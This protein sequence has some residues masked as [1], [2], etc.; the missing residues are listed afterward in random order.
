[1][2]TP[3]NGDTNWAGF[4]ENISG[5]QMNFNVPT[6]AQ[7]D[8]MFD[9]GRPD[10]LKSWYEQQRAAGNDNYM[11]QQAWDPNNSDFI[12]GLNNLWTSQQSTGGDY[13]PT[14]SPIDRGQAAGWRLTD[15]ANSRLK[16]GGWDLGNP[17]NI[18]MN[19]PTSEGGVAWGGGINSSDPNADWKNLVSSMTY[20]NSGTTA[21]NYDYT[22][23]PASGRMV[24]TKGAGSDFIT[25]SGDMNRKALAAFG[26]VVGA[27]L[28]IPAIAG[29]AGGAGAGAVAGT[30][31]MGMGAAAG[32]AAGSFSGSAL[33]GMDL[34]N[35]LQYANYASKGLQYGGQLT[36]NETLANIGRY[37]NMFTGLGT[38]V[39]GLVDGA[40][41]GNWF[42]ALKG[43]YGAYSSGNKI[44]NSLT[45]D[46]SSPAGRVRNPMINPTQGTGTGPQMSNQRNW[47]DQLL[48]IGAGVNS[49]IQNREAFTNLNDLFSRREQMRA[50]FEQKLLESYTNPRGYLDTPEYQAIASVRANELA[51]GDAKLGRNA[52]DVDRERLMQAHAQK[53]IGDYRSGLQGSINQ[54]GLPYE[55]FKQAQDRNANRGGPTMGG[56][57]Y[58]GATASIIDQLVKSGVSGPTLQQ[59][60]SK[61]GGAFGGGFEPNVGGQ[62]PTDYGQVPGGFESDFPTD[63]GGYI[64][65]EGD[66]PMDVGIPEVSYGSDLPFESD[67]PIDTGNW[68]FTDWSWDW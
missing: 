63:G 60:I 68:D 32:E 43:A 53:A 42:D 6:F 37:G 16:A 31:G 55:I 61:I 17:N 58:S 7:S 36:G 52:N 65:F 19:A 30:E 4:N 13:G 59:I 8:F 5:N 44:Y 41:S 46:P 47:M 64:P 24:P 38:G 33:G 29:A 2:Y 1:M 18:R 67:F 27:G 3:F 12:G 10:Q 51:R 50:P 34:G 25:N 9:Q 48:G 45:Q 28:A 57:G 21:L 22:F 49:D 23:D 20:K 56:L 66:Y 15:E 39:D 14:V 35:A 54:M 11:F 40:G 62:G 26:L